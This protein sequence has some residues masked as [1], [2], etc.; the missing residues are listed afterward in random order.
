LKGERS[1][2]VA[3]SEADMAW[4][5]DFGLFHS[6]EIPESAAGLTHPEIEYGAGSVTVGAFD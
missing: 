3:F 4:D 6:G 5:I 2:D 1:G